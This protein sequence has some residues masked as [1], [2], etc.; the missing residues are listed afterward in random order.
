MK[1][2]P[3]PAVVPAVGLDER[4]WAAL[5][6]PW[7]VCFDEGWQAFRAGAIPVGAAVVDGAGQVLARGRNGVGSGGGR[8]GSHALAHAELDALFGVDDRL[9]DH[10]AALYALLE[11]CPAC[12]G[13]FYMSGLRRLHFAAHDP[14]AGSA[15]LLGRTPYLR[16]KPIVLAP[17]SDPVLALV[18]QALQLVERRRRY[19]DLL[20]D[21]L[22]ERWQ[23]RA[24]AAA[25][26]GLALWREGWLTGQAAAGA[27]A[28]VVYDTL[29]A[30]ASA[31]AAAAAGG[32]AV[33]GEAAR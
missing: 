9:L 27:P 17:P 20:D 31:A 32:Q 25:A 10:R 24:P 26:W 18:V 8:L 1:R 15:N 30:R 23:R 6:G 3:V 2:D 19:P 28:A 21:P 12:F 4:P 33:Q 5:P 16:L 13:G 22:V 14:W 29:A 11:P 7:Q